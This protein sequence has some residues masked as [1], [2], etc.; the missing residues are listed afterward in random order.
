MPREIAILLGHVAGGGNFS[1]EEMSDAIDAIMRGQ[2][3][4]D[5]IGLLLTALA[6]KGETVEDDGLRFEVSV[7]TG[8]VKRT[9][10]R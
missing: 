4:D 7:P 3:S 1:L 9:G 5:Q 8:E 6:A 2:W 10:G